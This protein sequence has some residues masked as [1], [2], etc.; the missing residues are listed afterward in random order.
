MSKSGPKSKEP[1]IEHQA[2]VADLR[3]AS[4]GSVEPR[5]GAAGKLKKQIAGAA[6]QLGGQ[7]REKGCVP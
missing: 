7:Q 3:L 1:G 4:G 6:E 2:A 5:N